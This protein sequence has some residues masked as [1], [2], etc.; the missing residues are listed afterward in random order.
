MQTQIV[1]N[2]WPLGEFGANKTL[3]RDQDDA[4]VLDSE[5]SIKDLFH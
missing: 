1:Q 4:I 2:V 5:N 3:S